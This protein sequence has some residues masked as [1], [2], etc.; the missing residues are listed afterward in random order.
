M[1]QL[2]A[3][4]QSIERTWRRKLP[5]IDLGSGGDFDDQAAN[6]RK[7]NSEHFQSLI[8]SVKTSRNKNKD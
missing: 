7:R 5:A 4:L 3:E 1:S 2:R 8:N 6:Y